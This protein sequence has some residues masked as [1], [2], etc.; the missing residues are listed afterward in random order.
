MEARVGKERFEHVYPFKSIIDAGI[1][2]AAGS[3]CPV[4]DPDP[5]LGLHAM[6]T[7][8]GYGPQECVSINDALK[9]YTING[10]YAAFEEDVKGSIEVGKLADL[11][12]L[13]RNPLEISKDEIRDLEVVETIIRGKTIYKRS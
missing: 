7:R 3:D 4:E 12:M 2:L 9:T 10:A 6:V 5:I 8:E 11:V 1:I 13:N